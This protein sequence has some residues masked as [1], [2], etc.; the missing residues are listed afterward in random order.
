M[1]T[2][3]WLQ[4]TTLLTNTTDRISISPVSIYQ[5]SFTSTLTV[6]PLSSMDSDSF[7]CRA[8]V[9]SPG[10]V[11]SVTASDLGEQTVS[12]IVQGIKWLII[13]FVHSMDIS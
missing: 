12:V 4:G 8:G 1:I 3:K 11:G 10:G 9:I 5:L 13:W 2:I 7:T 6:F